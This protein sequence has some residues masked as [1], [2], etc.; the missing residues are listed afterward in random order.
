MVNVL[1]NRSTERQILDFRPLGFRD[2]MVLGRYHYNEVHRPLEPHDH[3]EAMEICLLD[4][5]CQ[6]Y[7][8][9]GC[10]YALKGG[11]VLFTAPHEVHSTGGNPEDRGTMYWLVLRVPRPTERFLYLSPKAQQHLFQQLF[12]LPS[13]MFSSRGR[14]KPQLDLIMAAYAEA[15][16]PLRNVNLANRL[17]RFLLDFIELGRRQASAEVSEPIRGVQQYVKSHLGQPLGVTELAA[18]ARLSPSRFK[19]RFRQE[20]GLSPSDYVLQLKA[21]EAKRQLACEGKSITD[22]AFGLGFCTSQYFSTVFRKITGVSP[23]NY[24]RTQKRFGDGGQC[25]MGVADGLK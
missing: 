25:L 5:G 16:N 17:L 9:G 19:Q 3:G 4:R 7:V 10:H 18:V 2:V 22:I 14:L 20:T 6:T 12:G 15:D 11:D 8:V 13:R 23:G 1:I 21:A 24:R